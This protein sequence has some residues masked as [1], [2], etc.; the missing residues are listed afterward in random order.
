MLPYYPL[1]TDESDLSSIA[2]GG[3]LDHAINGGMLHTSTQ[4]IL[5]DFVDVQAQNL[6]ILTIRFCKPR[7][8][9]F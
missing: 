2:R 5:G 7:Q 9:M 6:Y 1:Y 8:D 4:K 3:V